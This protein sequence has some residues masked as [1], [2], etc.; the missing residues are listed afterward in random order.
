[1][2]IVLAEERNGKQLPEKSFNQAIIRIGRNADDCQIV[3]DNTQ[4]PM[5]SRGHAELRWQNGMWFLHD[6]DSTFGTFIDGQKINAPQPINF[7][8]VLQ[9]GLEGPVL[10]VIWFEMSVNTPPI[11][12]A[13]PLQSQPV[14]QFVDDS[15]PASPEISTSNRPNQTNQSQT[16]ALEFI[17]GHSASL[18][19]QIT[20]EI[21]SLGRDPNGD[22]VFE[23]SAAAMVS[24]KHAEIRRQNNEFTLNDNGSFNGTLVNGQRIST[25]TPLYHQDEIQFGMG[26]PVLRFVA[27]SLV[28]P[29]GASLA[30]QRSIAVGQIANLPEKLGSQTIAF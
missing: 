15:F 24:R 20:K 18:P 23:S 2:K 12:S 16:A 22:V 11:P 3:F 28:A 9:F 30:G 27:P 21:I 7:D 8:S 1:M 13:N 14:K 17:S 4:F 19:F 5:V 10:R 26:G 6:L 29:K 25:P